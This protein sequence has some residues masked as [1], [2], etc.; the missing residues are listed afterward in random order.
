MT[1]RESAWLAMVQAKQHPF[2]RAW[3]LWIGFWP[4][5]WP[6]TML[7]IGAAGLRIHRSG[8]ASMM[9]YWPKQWPPSVHSLPAEQ[10][11]SRGVT[12]TDVRSAL[13][14]GEAT[15][16]W[17]LMTG[18]VLFVVQ[19]ALATFAV[20]GLIRLETWVWPFAAA[21]LSAPVVVWFLKMFVVVPGGRWCARLYLR[22]RPEV[23]CGAPTKP[24]REMSPE[25]RS[26]HRHR[27]LQGERPRTKARRK[28]LE[29]DGQRVILAASLTRQSSADPTRDQQWKGSGQAL[30]ERMRP[31]WEAE[32]VIVLLEPANWELAVVYMRWGAQEY[33][34]SRR[35]LVLD[36]R[37]PE[38]RAAAPVTAA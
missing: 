4:W 10:D 7:E 6:A 26:A 30:I 28:R 21:L 17:A 1:F 25:E 34:G 31:W 29:K 3:R 37:S 22:R 15:N 11:R 12:T 14:R 33:A 20:V 8:P 38:A 16:F 18:R 24:V 13:A 35:L 23:S 36:Y 32:E 5:F 9:T 27:F 2:G 19:A